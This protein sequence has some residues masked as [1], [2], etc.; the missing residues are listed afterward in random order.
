[1]N[2]DSAVRRSP[3]TIKILH[4]ICLFTMPIVIIVLVLLPNLGFVPVFG[5]DDQDLLAIVEIILGFLSL[6]CLFIGFFWPKLARW[7]K[8]KIRVAAEVLYGHILRMSFF[9]SL[10]IYSIILRLLGSEWYIV[11]PIL[12]LAGVALILTFPTDRRFSQW[13]VGRRYFY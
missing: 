6:L 3:L 9:E 2:S 8:I 1:M 12:I 10:I 7:H 13:Q 11:L 4:I 5:S